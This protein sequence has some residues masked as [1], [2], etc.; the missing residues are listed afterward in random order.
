MAGFRIIDFC[1][2]NFG[3]RHE[4]NKRHGCRMRSPFRWGDDAIGVP[5]MRKANSLKA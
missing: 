1:V 3:L 5:S 4:A 2:P